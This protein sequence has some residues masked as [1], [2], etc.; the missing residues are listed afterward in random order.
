ALRLGTKVE[1]ESKSLGGFKDEPKRQSTVAAIPRRR[2][3]PFPDLAV[4]IARAIR[5]EFRIVNLAN[6]TA[7][8]SLVEIAPWRHCRQ[9]SFRA[10]VKTRVSTNRADRIGCPLET[11]SQSR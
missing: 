3:R 11:P 5:L 4:T 1:E 10:D 2:R 9:A 7:E 6:E 8:K